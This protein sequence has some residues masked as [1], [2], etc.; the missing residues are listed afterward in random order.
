MNSTNHV[1]SRVRVTPS[2]G[3]ARQ[4]KASLPAHLTI[5]GVQCLPREVPALGERRADV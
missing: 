3:E 2:D 1:P 5:R 4:S